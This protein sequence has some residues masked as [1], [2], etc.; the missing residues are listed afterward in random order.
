MDRG[1]Q[2]RVRANVSKTQKEGW[3]HETSV[4]VTAGIESDGLIEAQ[5]AYWLSKADAIGKVEADRRNA[6]DGDPIG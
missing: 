1:F 6:R 4:E 5:L 2:I 3:K